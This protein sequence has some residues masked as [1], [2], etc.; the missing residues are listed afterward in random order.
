M[1]QTTPL[2]FA[3][4]LLPVGRGLGEWLG[5]L[6]HVRGIPGRERPRQGLSVAR[7]Y[8]RRLP[9]S[10]GVSLAPQRPCVRTKPTVFVPAA[11][12]GR[13]SVVAIAP[14]GVAGGPSV[15]AGGP[16]VVAGGPRVVAGGPSVV[17]SGPSVV[18]G[19][20]RV[21]RKFPLATHSF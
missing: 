19:G 16:S 11:V 15:V 17:A 3:E 18:A 21:P 14:G 2:H 13:P 5:R 6:A 12:A 9:R 1:A 7:E 20:H 4:A 10:P 8:E